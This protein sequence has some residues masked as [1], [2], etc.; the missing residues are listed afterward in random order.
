[1]NIAAGSPMW[2]NLL[3]SP[4]GYRVSG[5]F[6]HPSRGQ[7]LIQAHVKTLTQRRVEGRPVAKPPR[8]AGAFRVHPQGSSSWAWSPAHFPQCGSRKPTRNRTLKAR[9]SV[10][11]PPRPTNGPSLS[12]QPQEWNPRKPVAKSP[13]EGKSEPTRSTRQSGF[14]RFPQSGCRC[15]KYRVTPLLS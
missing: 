15:R 2:P 11:Q 6:R 5:T 3:S 4:S 9:R 14:R 7:A 8:N 1:M 13:T 10:R 12:G